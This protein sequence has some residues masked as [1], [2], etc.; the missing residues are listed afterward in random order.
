METE[1]NLSLRADLL[2]VS[3]AALGAVLPRADQPFVLAGKRVTSA[4]F[5]RRLRSG[6]MLS[7][8]SF[9]ADSILTPE[10][11]HTWKV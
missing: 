11:R 10:M 4:A 3:S 5:H 8:V 6:A 2:P 1:K 9:S 7:L